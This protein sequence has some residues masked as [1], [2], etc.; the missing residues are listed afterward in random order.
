V[1]FDAGALP[2]GLYFY[3]LETLQGRKLRKLVV[4]K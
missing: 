3:R 2:S 1:S 4:L